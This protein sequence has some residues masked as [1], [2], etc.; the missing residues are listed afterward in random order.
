MLENEYKKIMDGSSVNTYVF[1]SCCHKVPVSC[2]QY[3]TF[4]VSCITTV[5]LLDTILY[6]NTLNCDKRNDTYVT[7]IIN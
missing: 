1:C 7:L 6:H 2:L 3:G 4:Y 5:K